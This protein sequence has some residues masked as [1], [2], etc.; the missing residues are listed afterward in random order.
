MATLS[1]AFGR[2]LGKTVELTQRIDA[3][4]IGGVRVFVDNK[5]LDQSLRGRLDGLRDTMK[6]ARIGAGG[7]STAAAD[8]PPEQN[9]TSE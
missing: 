9:E 6:S 8:G 5:M 7:G 1:Q 4:L 2:L 3:D